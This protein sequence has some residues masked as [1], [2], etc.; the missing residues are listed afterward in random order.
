MNRQTKVFPTEHGRWD[1]TISLFNHL[2]W[3]LLSSILSVFMCFLVFCPMAAAVENSGEAI[4]KHL[5]AL[6]NSGNHNLIE[7]LNTNPRAF[8]WKNAEEFK[9]KGHLRFF[10]SAKQGNADLTMLYFIR[11]TEGKIFILTISDGNDPLYQ[12]LKKLIESKLDFSI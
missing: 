11:S 9:F 10:A 6:A 4:Y 1:L 7:K 3:K 8:D 2:K 5:S 12:N